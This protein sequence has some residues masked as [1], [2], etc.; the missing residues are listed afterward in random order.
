M[1]DTARP[2]IYQNLE[3]TVNLLRSLQILPDQ[4]LTVEERL[5][6]ASEARDHLAAA[7]NALQVAQREVE[8]LRVDNRNL[9][10]TSAALAAA[11]A[12]SSTAS[13][14]RAT[15]MTDPDKFDGTRSKYLTFIRSMR[16]KLSEP[17]FVDEPTKLR[18]LV[19]RLEG[20]ALNQVG[21][22]IT[23]AGVVVDEDPLRNTAERL[24]EILATA[25]DD[26]DRVRNATRQL[27]VIKQGSKEFSDHYAAFQVLA[28]DVNWTEENLRITL[29]SSLSYDLQAALLTTAEPPVWDDLIALLQTTDNRIRAL[30]AR[31]PRTSSSVPK[32]AKAAHPTSSNSGHY[33]PA[34]M[35]LSAGRRRG[36]LTQ[37][38]R[39][40]RIAQGLCLYCGGSGHLAMA[41]PNRRPAR[42]SAAVLAPVRVAAAVLAPRPTTPVIEEGRLERM[43]R[44]EILRSKN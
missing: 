17:A 24:L 1:G 31:N 29:M 25:F 16:L 18:Y 30:N 44:E 34:P 15:K 27:N 39:Q 22:F 37:E 3:A 36:P 2:Q 11:P 7:N 14:A 23:G 35:D 21:R 33:G 13:T 28:A 40:R 12:S 32:P 8:A 38:E 5:A 26:P 6:E 41:C 20:T 43:E 4:R 42:V 10:T 19:G 9:A